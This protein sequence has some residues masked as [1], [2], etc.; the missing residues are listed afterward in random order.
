MFRDKTNS[1]HRAASKEDVS[2]T[3]AMIAKF[4]IERPTSSIR[5]T[6]RKRQKIR[7]QITRSSKR[8]S[9][10]QDKMTITKIKSRTTPFLPQRM[11]KTNLRKTSEVK[12]KSSSELWHS[13]RSWP[14]GRC[15][16]KCRDKD[17]WLS[18]IRPSSWSN[19][20]G[21]SNL[22]C[23]L[24]KEI[25]NWKRGESAKK[26]CRISERDS[27]KKLKLRRNQTRYKNL[28]SQRLQM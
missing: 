1:S 21:L 13:S 20:P 2:L 8:T 12:K 22:H 5:R 14:E 26:N 10:H 11:I 9:K 28:A 18:M 24:M 7:S 23:N 19:N 15:N 27:M 3:R 25:G 17:P 16:K 4:K 6:W